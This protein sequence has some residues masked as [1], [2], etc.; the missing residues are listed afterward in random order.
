MFKKGI[1]QGLSTYIPFGGQIEPISTEGDKLLWKNAQKNATKKKISETIKR[2]IPNLN[3]C[4][5]KPVWW[6]SKFDSL[7]TSL[8]QTNIILIR[9]IILIKRDIPPNL[10]VWK[11]KTALI[12]HEKADREA[13]KGQ[14]LGST[15]WKGCFW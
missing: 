10:K 11:Y 5:T 9:N 2:R 3:P 14:G 13:K 12:V 6:P 7:E 1:C 15:K 8:H 4:C